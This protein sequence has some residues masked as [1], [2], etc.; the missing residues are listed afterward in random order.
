MKILFVNPV[1]AIG[2]AERSLLTIMAALRTAEL[3][4]ELYLIAGTE[5]PL[6]ANAESLGVQVKVLKLPDAVSQLGDSA[7][8]GNSPFTGAF[9]LLVRSAWILPALG[10]YLVDFRRSLREISPDIIHSNGIKAHLLSA[11]AGLKKVPVVWHIRDFYG[12]RPLVARMLNWASGSAAV[13]I[14]IS[15]AVA[16]DARATLPHLPIQMIYNAVDVNYFSPEDPQLEDMREA[17][18]STQNTLGDPSHRP[19]RIGLV[20]TFARW[21][22][23]DVFLEAAANVVRQRPDLNL[24]FYIIG[25]PIYKTQGSQFSEE[26]LR[27]QAANLQIQDQVDFL[28]FQA[29]IAE[30]YRGLDV[31]VHASTQPEPFGLAIVEAMACGKAVIVSQAGGAAELFT[32]NVD[33]VGV[34]PGDVAALSAAIAHLADNPDLRQCLADNAR[35]TATERFNHTRFSQQIGELYEQFTRVSQIEG[36]SKHKIF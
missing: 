16:A 12:S 28:G 17:N 19:L 30:V 18:T 32:H 6:I 1:G 36:T 25:G 14:A 13:G 9:K 3:N 11:L 5:G 24:R 2:G 20:A 21:K 4:L 27:D 31:A 29:D 34:P 35:K 8:K 33:A 15:E 23:H 7:L 26:E 10:Q 22:G